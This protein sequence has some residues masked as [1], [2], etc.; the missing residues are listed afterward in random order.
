[1]AYTLRRG[2]RGLG[3]CMAVSDLVAQCGGTG[4]GACSPLDSACVAT[5]TSLVSWAED[6]QDANW[7]PEGPCIPPGTSCPG[8]VASQVAAG[9]A[10]TQPTGLP[11]GPSGLPYSTGTTTWQGQTAYLWSDGSMTLAPVWGQNVVTPI[12]ATPVV[13]PI[14][15][16][17]P[18]SIAPTTVQT[19]PAGSAIVN[20]SGASG[21]TAPSPASN[22]SQT[23]PPASTNWF[24]DTTQEMI[25]GVPNWVLVAA[26]AGIGLFFVIQGAHK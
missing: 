17:K 10:V 1:M 21:S 8:S 16:A 25:S 9:S 3:D 24:T 11:N 2:L 23:S 22:T 19:T 5:Q 14:A 12:A 18:V 7:G 13:P 15:P 4:S 26:A 20:S 6:I